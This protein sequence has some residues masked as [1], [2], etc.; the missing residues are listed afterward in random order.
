MKNCL[1]TINDYTLIVDNYKSA[2]DATLTTKVKDDVIGFVF[3][4]S[5][6]VDIEIDTENRKHKLTKKTGTISSFYCH[7]NTKITHRISK[8]K[9]LHKATVFITSK[10][11]HSFVEEEQIP[12]IEHFKGLLNPRDSY[13]NGN[14][15]LMTPQI[16]TTLNKLLNNPYS[17]ITQKLFLESQIIEL[18]SYYFDAIAS[19]NKQERQ[20]KDIDK[21]YQAKEVLINQIDSPPSLAELSKL[22]GLNSFKLKT[23][24][25]ELFGSPVYKYL[26]GKRLE[27]A[28]E[29]LEIKELSVQE[30]AWYVG[31]ESI[32]SFSNAFHKKFGVRPSEINK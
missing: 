8:K 6:D 2:E 11:L 17:G 30:V 20:N 28:F 18:L 10:K 13:V 9:P 25:K 21:L 32:G 22:T 7:E 1:K 19:A 29:L 23:G 3:Y 15:F 16:Q 24:F 27:K 26:Q 31:Y 5:G 4:G 12:Y 14:S